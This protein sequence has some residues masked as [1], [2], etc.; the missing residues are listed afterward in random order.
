MTGILS[1][2]TYLPLAGVAAILLI[3]MFGNG[4]DV[5]AASALGARGE[6]VM[7]LGTRV[8]LLGG[9]LLAGCGRHRAATLPVPVADR[10]KASVDSLWTAAE[11][12]FNRSGWG[13]ALKRFDQVAPAIQPGDAR[14]LRLHFFQ[15]EIQLAQ[16][17][18]LQAV[19]DTRRHGSNPGNS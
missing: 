15:G 16:G 3:R 8:A 9:V 6:T 11:A 10:P 12:A 7:N 2:T 18:N 17:N 5:R 19:R 1:L 13:E 14:Y 4:G